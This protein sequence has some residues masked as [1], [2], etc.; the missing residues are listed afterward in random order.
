MNSI[1]V[2][3]CRSM[4]AQQ[5]ADLAHVVGGEEEE[6]DGAVTAQRAH[7][8]HDVDAL[9]ESAGRLC[10]CM[11]TSQPLRQQMEMGP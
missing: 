9:P 7:D 5:G 6:Q 1:E 8:L 4:L 2:C 11:F 3:A 10:T